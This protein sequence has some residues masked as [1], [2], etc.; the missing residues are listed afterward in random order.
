MLGM[1]KAATIN[2]AQD[3]HHVLGTARGL[4]FRAQKS[5]GCGGS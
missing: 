1:T 3:D 2:L 4:G 5:G